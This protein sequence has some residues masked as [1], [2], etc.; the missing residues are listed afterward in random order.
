MK[1]IIIAVSLSLL[2]FMAMASSV[3]IGDVS[4][5]GNTYTANGSAGYTGGDTLSVTLD[6]LSLIS[7]STATTWDVTGDTTSGLHTLTASVGSESASREFRVSGGGGG[8]SPCQIDGTCPRFGQYAPRVWMQDL[9]I[10]PSARYVNP[11]EEG[12]PAFFKMKCLVK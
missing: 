11:G 7:G 2:P 10:A 6:S 8:L 1:K 12:C 4:S 5:S 9:G 3:S